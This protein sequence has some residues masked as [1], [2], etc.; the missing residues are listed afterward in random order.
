MAFQDSVR[1][2][3]SFAQVVQVPGVGPQEALQVILLCN[4]CKV[5]MLRLHAA[6]GEALHVPDN[7]KQ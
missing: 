3:E 6:A 1:C 5:T 2:A 7:D 4:P